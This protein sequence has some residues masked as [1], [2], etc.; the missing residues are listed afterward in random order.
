MTLRQKRIVETLGGIAI[1][2]VIGIGAAACTWQEW[3]HLLLYSRPIQYDQQG[4]HKAIA[5]ADRIVVR[6][7]GFG[8]CGQTT[9]DAVLLVISNAV[10]IREFARHVQF[11]PA[12]TTN[13]VMESCM[14]CGYPGIDWFAGSKRL[15][16][17]SVQHNKRLRWRGFSTLRILGRAVGYGD[18]PLTDES[19]QWLKTWLIAHRVLKPGPSAADD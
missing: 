4:F 19:A 11:Q 18:A 14:C 8:C 13:S 5:R 3:R 2:L 12:S 10:E 9:D 7:G 15:A 1:L 16:L 6:D 17:T